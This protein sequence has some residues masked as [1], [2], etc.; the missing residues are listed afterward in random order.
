[1][2]CPSGKTL[3]VEPSGDAQPV[4]TEGATLEPVPVAGPFAEPRPVAFPPDGKLLLP[5]RP[6]RLQLVGPGMATREVHGIPDVFT[7]GH[8]GPL[9]LTLDPDFAANNTIYLS[10]LQGDEMASTIRV[11]R[12]KLDEP[13]ETL[14]EQQ[15][16]FESSPGTKPEQLGGRRIG[17][18]TEGRQII[19]KT[20]RLT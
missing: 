18:T 15:T 6:G 3:T 17:E 10:Y 7:Q 4:L 5:E 16:M 1:L 11:L 8:G 19:A 13:N 20:S 2:G 12:A 9:D 14:T